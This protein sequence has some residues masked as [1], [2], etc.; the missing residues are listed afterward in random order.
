VLDVHPR[1][2]TIVAHSSDDVRTF[3]KA[4][5]FAHEAAPRLAFDVAELFSDLDLLS[6]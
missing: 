1:K 2:R 6:R 5:H 3:G 4:D